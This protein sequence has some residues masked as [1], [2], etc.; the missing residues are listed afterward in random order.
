MARPLRIEFA[1][2]LYHIT[3]RGNERRTIF[4]KDDDRLA[5]LSLLSDV[6][7]RF[8]WLCHAYCLM[9]NHYHLLVETPEAN[10]S[11]GMRQ[12]NGV[13][14][15]YINRTH[16]RVGHLFQG[17]F[18]GILVQKE[19]YLLELARYIMLNPVRAGMVADP[20]DWRWSSYRSSVGLEER[21]EFLTTEGLLSA[22]GEEPARARRG[23]ARFVAEGKDQASPWQDLKGQIYLGSERFV[24]AM[25][26]H[27][28]QD[29]PL[30]EIP[31]RQRRCIT[32]PLADYAEQFSDRDRA[33]AEAYRSGA[34]SMQAIADHFGVGRMTVSR[35]VRKHPVD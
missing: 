12:L 5:F 15:Q 6:V 2:S 27:I 19:V 17:R 32:R 28:R 26:Q 25:Q 1:G 29:Q 13:Y 21:P 20:A 35:A 18:K 11:K 22:F 8:S 7:H 24:E 30:R 16:R 14:T 34:Y 33:M 4:F 3:S 10:L 23:F 31:L 9:G